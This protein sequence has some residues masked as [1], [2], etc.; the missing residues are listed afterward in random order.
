[1]QYDHFS[2][3]GFEVEYPKE[4]RVELHPKSKRK[5]GEVAFQSPE[6][7]RM[8]VFWGELEEA[9]KK[10]ASLDEYV[11]K[12]IK[13]VKKSRDVN[14]VEVVERKELEINGHRAIFTNLRATIIQGFLLKRRKVPQNLWA[15]HL[16][17]EQTSRFF[18]VH[19]SPSSDERSTE[20]AKVYEHMQKSFRCHTK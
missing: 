15:S 13:K 20:H 17:C 14:S 3:H 2:I 9:K 1:M 4:W 12:T 8:F 6:R 7:D 16:Y 18:I 5:T 10:F 19:G 11:E